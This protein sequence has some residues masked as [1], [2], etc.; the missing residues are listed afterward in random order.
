MNLY[1]KKHASTGTSS[2]EARWPSPVLQTLTTKALLMRVSIIAILLSFSGLLLAGES[3]GQ[4]LDKV[5]VSVQF[6]NATLKNAL[7]K[8]EGLTN[9]P[10]AYKTNDVAPYDNINYQATDI[11]LSTLLNDLFRSTDLRYEQVNS[12]IIIK[13]MDRSEGNTASKESGNRLFDGIIRGRVANDKGEALP[14]TSVQ[15]IGT[16]K[17]TVANSNGEFVITGV[18]A[19]TYRISVSVVGY[20]D[21]IREVTVRDN[22]ETSLDFQ[23]K[24]KSGSMTEVVVTALGISRKE[25]SLGYSTQVV[26]GENLTLTK[27]QNVLGSLAGKIAGV[28]VTGS[29]GASLGG[30]QKIKIR[31]VNSIGGTDQP[32]IVVDGTPISNANFAGSDKADFGNLGQDVN[33]EDIETVDVLKSARSTS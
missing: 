6:K 8:I 33:P 29:S 2:T 9:L 5:M 11:P 18:K 16:S 17:G 12:N 20:E 30:T 23:L 24:E 7:R 14:N 25:R 4:D 26:K 21:E 10:F 19:G 13:K 32:L 31:G 22:E 3:R 28:Q 15:L 1:V 27:E